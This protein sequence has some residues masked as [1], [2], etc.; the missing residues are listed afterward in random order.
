MSL[1]NFNIVVQWSD[2]MAV[3]SPSDEH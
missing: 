1:K 2:N 3:E